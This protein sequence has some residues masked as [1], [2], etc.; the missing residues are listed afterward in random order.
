MVRQGLLAVASLGVLFACS[1]GGGGGGALPCDGGACAGQGGSAGVGG[2]GA[3]GGASGGSGAGGGSGAAGGTGGAPPCAPVGFSASPDAFSVPAPRCQ[4]PFD[5]FAKSSY[6]KIGYAL[7]DLGGD[8]VSDLVVHRD[9][10]D[11]SVGQNHWD[12]YPG[13]ASGFAA[14]PQSLSIP[15]PRCQEKFDE[16]GKSSYSK[17]AYALVDLTGDDQPDLVVHR[18]DCDASVG[19]QRWDVYTGSPSG[20]SQAPVPFSIPAA[21]CQEKF[22]AAGKSSYSAVAYALLDLTGDEL[23]DL[24]VHRDDCDASVGQ[25]RWDVYAGSASGFAA[26]PKS[27]GLPAARCQESFDALAKS[28]YSAVG[29][30]LLDLTADQFPDL[31]VH[32]DDCDAAVGSARWDVYAGSPSG[33]GAAPSAFGLPAPRCQESFDATAKSSYSAVGYALFDTSAKGVVDLA[34]H[35]DDCDADVGLSRWDVYRSSCSR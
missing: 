10:C 27:F 34:V 2:A 23:P 32:R 19:Q 35:R 29:Y 17:I 31:V 14:A 25:A 1:G 20:F 30:V 18:D 26:A 28:S 21:R 9:D 16:L 3:A 15:A 33:F 13:S 5:A 11:A 12:L 7:V 8:D 22:D 24:V 4:E 6:S